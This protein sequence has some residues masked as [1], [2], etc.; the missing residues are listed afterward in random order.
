MYEFKVNKSANDIEDICIAYGLCSILYMNDIEFKLKDNLSM[1]SIYTEEFD[2]EE[3]VYN[4]IL[5]KPWNLNSTSTDRELMGGADKN[6]EIKKGRIEYMNEFIDDN[7]QDILLKYLGR[8]RSKEVDK[9]ISATSMGNVY[10]ANGIRAGLKPTSQRVNISNSYLSLLGFIYG[11]SYCKNAKTEINMMLKPIETSEI[12]KPYNFTYQDKETGVIKPWVKPTTNGSHVNTMAIMIVE[13]LINYSMVQK[14]YSDIICIKYGKS[15]NKPLM[16]KTYNIKIPCLSIEFL[17]DFKKLLTWSNVDDD[18][19]ESVSNYILDM[20]SYNKLSKMIRIMS[21]TNSLINIK[22]KEEMIG[23][24]ENKNKI[25]EIYNSDTVI[26]LGKGL[27]RLLRDNRGFDIQVK[28]YSITN[29][30]HLQRCIR[31]LIDSYRRGYKQYLLND[32]ELK[33]LLNSITNNENCKICADAILSYAK[34]FITKKE[35]EK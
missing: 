10:Y 25:A 29:Q 23:M 34:V 1:Y 32:E 18:V 27:N 12:K 2:L 33:S 26:K 4:D 22:F 7:L 19:R 9:S 16:D 35:E 5:G 31:M 28:L 21:K 17:N 14:E 11:A 24:F 20:Y 30:M 15:S 3:V 6:G 8:E 13:T